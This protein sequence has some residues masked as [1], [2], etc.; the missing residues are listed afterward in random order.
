M[1]R[2][3]EHLLVVHAPLQPGRLVLCAVIRGMLVQEKCCC[4][5]V[6]T[7]CGFHWY[8]VGENHRRVP[9]GTA[10]AAAR[11]VAHYPPVVARG[12]MALALRLVHNYFIYFLSPCLQGQLM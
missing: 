3:S 10:R 2:R 11:R 7:V 9:R 6:V 1:V 12:P 8:C 4:A 5:I